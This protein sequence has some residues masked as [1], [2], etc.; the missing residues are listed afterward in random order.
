MLQALRCLSRLALRE[1]IQRPLQDQFARVVR[2]NRRL[3]HRK[4]QENRRE[5]LS[6]Q[7]PREAYLDSWSKP[8]GNAAALCAFARNILT[9]LS[10]I[11]FSITAPVTTSVARTTYFPVGSFKEKGKLN[12]PRPFSTS[13]LFE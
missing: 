7:Q 4:H 9:Y 2:C 8:L 1:R 13:T 10:S 5:E 3:Q 12:V 6:N 11:D